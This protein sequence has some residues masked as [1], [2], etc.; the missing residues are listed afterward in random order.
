MGWISS[1]TSLGCE[2]GSLSGALE[3]GLTLDLG[4]SGYLELVSLLWVLHW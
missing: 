3:S 1:G 4:L 2:A